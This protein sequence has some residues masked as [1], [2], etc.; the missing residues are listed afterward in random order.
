[1]RR[2]TGWGRE[3]IVLRRAVERGGSGGGGAFGFS[4]RGFSSVV[5]LDSGSGFGTATAP[6][7]ASSVCSWLNVDSRRA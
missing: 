6:S 1:M 2:T 5:V 3:R 7:P 4:A